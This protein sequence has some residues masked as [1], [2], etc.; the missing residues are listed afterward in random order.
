M[1]GSSGGDCAVFFEEA[2]MGI[3]TNF[4][5]T[6]SSMSGR[7][8]SKIETVIDFDT[9]ADIADPDALTRPVVALSLDIDAEKLERTAHSHRKGQLSYTTRGIA[10]LETE[11]ELW[12]APP[13]SAVWIPGGW[14]RLRDVSRWK[15]NTLR[16]C[17]PECNS[18]GK[19]LFPPRLAASR[20]HSV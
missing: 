9:I 2:S 17:V 6:G 18:R 16:S 5:Q 10:R 13:N 12:I 7:P 11:D 1:S 14:L 15:P 4:K 8:S 3:R 19:M 20:K